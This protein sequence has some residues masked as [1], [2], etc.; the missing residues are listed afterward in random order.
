VEEVEEE[1]EE[2]DDSSSKADPGPG[3]KQKSRQPAL[4]F[5][6]RDSLIFNSMTGDFFA[7]QIKL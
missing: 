3:S 6:S 1:Q 5:D 4:N 2:E 7:T